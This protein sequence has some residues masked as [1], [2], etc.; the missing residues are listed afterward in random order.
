MS[1]TTT[2]NPENVV[3][4]RRASDWPTTAKRRTVLDGG[5]V[6]LAFPGCTVP[7]VNKPR[8][9]RLPASIPSLSCARAE[10]QQRAEEAQH[11]AERLRLL[12]N[13]FVAAK[14]T[15]E[16]LR[17]NLRDFDAEAASGRKG[18]A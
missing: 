5:C 17:G 15:M 4:R 7:V 9:G 2:K 3:N 11:R 18:A 13:L 6:V 14:M 10:R 16:A 1:D 8:R 12:E